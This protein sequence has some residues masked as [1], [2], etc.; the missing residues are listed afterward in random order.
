MGSDNIKSFHK[1]KNAEFLA[2]EYPIIVYQRPDADIDIPDL[3]GIN[4]Q[5]NKGPLLN[6]SASF[7]RAEIKAD[8]SIRYM[9]PEPVYRYLLDNTIY[10]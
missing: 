10:K 7:I 4:V 8:R 3:E 2:K 1:W 9:V 6:I 5:T